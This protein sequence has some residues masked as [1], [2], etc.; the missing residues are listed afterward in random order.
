MSRDP[1]LPQTASPRRRPPPTRPAVLDEDAYQQALSDII[2]RDFFPDLLDMEAAD[3]A[4]SPHTLS[5]DTAHVTRNLSLD[6]FLA[7]YTSEDNAS[8]ADL[9]ARHN[10]RL[11]DAYRWAWDGNK[12][13]SAR[14][15]LAPPHADP[16]P[17]GPDAW[18][19]NVRPA[20]LR[21]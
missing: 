17:S 14:A 3:P 21:R 20:T 7:K 18:P 8:F 9:L 10:Q 16:R 1:P 13:R 19:F 6:Q 11:R 15:L 4:L 12:I 5:P 2:K